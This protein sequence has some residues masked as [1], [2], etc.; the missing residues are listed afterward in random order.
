MLSIGEIRALLNQDKGEKNTLSVYLDT[1][2]SIGTWKSKIYSLQKKLDSIQDSLGTKDKAQFTTE[3]TKLEKFLST[4]KP[5]G[6]CLAVFS[7][8]PV[9]L[10]WAKDVNTPAAESVTF[11][12]TPKVAP[13]VEMLD[14][15]QRFCAVTIDNE[16]ARIFLIKVSEIESVKHIKDFVPGKHKQTEFNARIEQ[17][18]RSMVQDHIKNVVE[19]I[20]SLQKKNQFNRLFLGGTPEARATF[21][22]LLSPDLKQILCGQFTASMNQTDDA[23]KKSAISAAN[24]YERAKESQTVETLETQALKNNGAVIGCDATLLELHNANVFK[25]VVAGDTTIKGCKCSACGF[26]SQ[27][28]VKKCSLC[29]GSTVRTDDLAEEAVQTAVK[30]GVVRIEVLKG[31][32]RDAFAEAYGMGAFLLR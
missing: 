11:S 28:I 7:S 30:K 25:L 6:K 8:S 14:E 15:Y 22:K 27:T 31:I 18:H 21:E 4:F 9:N 19:E 2:A 17:K 10:W 3:R 20:K 26:A 5:Q 1:D 32:E 23:I 12:R 24:K 13:L 16:S 29:G